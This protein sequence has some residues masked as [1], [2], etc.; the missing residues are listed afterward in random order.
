MANNVVPPTFYHQ[1]YDH[2]TSDLSPDTHR[3]REDESDLESGRPYWLIDPLFDTRGPSQDPRPPNT[4]AG[5]IDWETITA[6][7]PEVISPS[8]PEALMGMA[9]FDTASV[10]HPAYSVNS[11]IPVLFPVPHIHLRAPTS[12]RTYP[13]PRTNLCPKS[14]LD[15]PLLIPLGR[16]LTRRRMT[17]YFVCPGEW[18]VNRFRI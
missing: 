8:S 1:P 4:P 17:A 16:L 2:G 9:V 13:F 18:N 7:T 15:L 14:R 5:P 10:T 11:H 12:A 6:R 3:E